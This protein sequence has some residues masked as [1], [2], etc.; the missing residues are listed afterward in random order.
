MLNKLNLKKYLNWSVASILILSFIIGTF[1]VL[2]KFFIGII[3]LVAFLLLIF[4][5]FQLFKLNSENKRLLN[6]LKSKGDFIAIAAHQIRAPLSAIKWVLESLEREPLNS[7]QSELVQTGMS[8]AGSL[9]EIVEDLLNISKI[10]EGAQEYNFQKINLIEFLNFVLE[11]SAPIATEYKIK[12]RLEPVRE[13]SVSVTADPEK[14][15]LAVTNLLENAI[16]YNI[17][18]GQVFVGIERQSNNSFIQVNISDTGLGIP[19]EAM[20]K[21]FT[22]FF[23]AENAIS[24]EASGSGLG[25]YIV[26]NVIEHHGGRIWVDSVVN[27]GTTFHFTLPIYR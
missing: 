10:E 15:S 17:E 7:G 2:D 25:L 12:F 22:K 4:L 8:A 11:K 19:Q 9:V 20:K 3:F 26:R 13:Q 24:K 14:L 18:N 27:K 23:R 16:K 5:A 1:A 21:L 6:S